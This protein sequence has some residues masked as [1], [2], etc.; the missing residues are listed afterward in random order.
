[1]SQT[2]S[3]MASCDDANAMSQIWSYTG[4]HQPN[5]IICMP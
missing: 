1:M 2:C 3:Y 4:S 5:I